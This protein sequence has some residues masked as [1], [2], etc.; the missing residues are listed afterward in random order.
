MDNPEKVDPYEAVLAD[1]RARR[2]QL[3]DAIRTLEGLRGVIAGGQ[4]TQ[5][6]VVAATAKAATPP[7]RAYGG[8]SDGDTGESPY[9]GMTIPDATKALLQ[10][11]RRQMQ[12]ADIVAA[13][14]AGGLILTSCDKNNTVGSVLLRRFYVVGDIVRINRGVWG[15]QEWYPGRKFPGAK[16]KAGDVAKGEADTA[17]E[18]LSENEAD[19]QSDNEP[20][21]DDALELGLDN[22]FPELG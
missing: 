7:A 9:L 5:A 22:E 17:P 16:S 20:H 18:S 13:L 6:P 8:G 12:T 3:D 11:K 1:L 21:D 4:A 2:A 19:T 10:S 15:L 14:E